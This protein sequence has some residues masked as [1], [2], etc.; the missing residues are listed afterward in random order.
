MKEIRDRLARYENWFWLNIECSLGLNS[1]V[2]R[3]LLRAYQ[4][5]LDVR[6][7]V[8]IQNNKVKALNALKE[9]ECTFGAARFAWSA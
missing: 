8:L 7:E 5:L 3:A 6:G 1:N 9:F 4:R 2:D